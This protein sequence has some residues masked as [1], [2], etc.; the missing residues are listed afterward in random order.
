MIKKNLEGQLMNEQIIKTQT[1][2]NMILYVFIKGDPVRGNILSKYWKTVLIEVNKGKVIFLKLG[3]TNKR[4]E[5][6]LPRAI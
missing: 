5:W 3:Q 1:Q 2:Y 4:V 6:W